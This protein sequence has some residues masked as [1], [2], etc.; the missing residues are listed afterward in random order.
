MLKIAAFG[1]KSDNAWERGT[2]AIRRRILWVADRDERQAPLD[3]SS[4]AV[5][6]GKPLQAN[7]PKRLSARSRASMWGPAGV[8]RTSMRRTA[9]RPEDLGVGGL[10]RRRIDDVRLLPGIVDEELV[11]CE[12]HLPHQ[13]AA[14][15]SHARCRSQKVV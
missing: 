10:A 1:A 11:A 14:A 7:E 15:S 8:Q 12:V 2:K 3:A 4:T 9:G 6:G 13:Q 5:A